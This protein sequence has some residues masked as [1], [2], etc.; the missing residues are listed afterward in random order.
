MKNGK[1]LTWKKLRRKK[2]I[3]TEMRKCEQKVETRNR[4]QPA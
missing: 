3:L 1:V 2:D 4:D